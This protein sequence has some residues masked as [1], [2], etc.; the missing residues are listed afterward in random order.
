MGEN[1]K[2]EWA[3]HTLNFWIGCE[4]VSEACTFCYAE[5]ETYPRVQRARGRELWGRNA[6]RHR[7]AESTWRKAVGWDAAAAERGERH[8]VFIN[9]LSDFFEDRP[10]LNAWRRDAWVVI[11]NCENLDFLLLTKRPE[12]IARMLPPG[13]GGGWPNVWLMATVENQRRA[14]ERMPH[15]LAVPAVVRGVSMEPLLDDVDM[16]TWLHRCSFDGHGEHSAF[17]DACAIR[18]MA[19]EKAGIAGYEALP[20]AR[21][22][23]AILGGGSGRDERTFDFA[24]ARR[25]KAQFQAAGT[26]V[27]VKQAGQVAIDRDADGLLRLGLPGDRRK[28]GDPLDWPRDMRVREF[29]ATRGS[30]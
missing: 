19:A 14:D 25:L 27:F 1:T 16:R 23:W 5:V 13:W 7:T 29:P 2:I 10:D 4:K 12:N 15:L 21:L 18:E 6:D 9:S 28:G 11:A 30:Q 8:R 20:G 24:R 3:H 26:R 17:C 22:H